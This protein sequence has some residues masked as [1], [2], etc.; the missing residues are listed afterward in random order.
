MDKDSAANQQQPSNVSADNLA[1]NLQPAR[2]RSSHDQRQRDTEDI[3]SSD[4]IDFEQATESMQVELGDALEDQRMVSSSSAHASAVVGTTAV[5]LASMYLHQET[6]LTE[7]GAT[8]RLLAQQDNN[9]QARDISS[10][11]AW[12]NN[13]FRASLGAADDKDADDDNDDGEPANVSVAN[14]KSQLSFTFDEDDF[15]LQHQDPLDR[16][17]AMTKEN[18]T[19]WATDTAQAEMPWL[20]RR[21]SVIREE[22]S[23]HQL[24]PFATQTP[25]STSTPLAP[26]H[27]NPPLSTLGAPPRPPSFSHQLPSSST[28]KQ[29]PATDSAYS[30]P[31]SHLTEQKRPSSPSK[32]PIIRPEMR[33][34]G[35]NEVH[36]KPSIRVIGDF[37]LPPLKQLSPPHHAAFP[38][39]AEPVQEQQQKQQVMATADLLP[40]PELPGNLTAVRAQIHEQLAEQTMSTSKLDLAFRN[41]EST[42]ARPP[43]HGA[44][45]NAV[46]SQMTLLELEVA[47]TLDISNHQLESLD[48]LHELAPDL[49]ECNT[50]HNRLRFL[51]GLPHGLTKLNAMSNWL[52]NLTS[53]SHL[54]NLQYLNISDNAIDDLMGLSGC[55][56]LRELVAD[57]NGI[58]SLS[59]LP[60]I[61]GLLKL[62]LRHNVIMHFDLTPLKLTRLE[63]LDL[64]HNKIV[65]IDSLAAAP[66][67]VSL[68]LDHNDIAAFELAEPA[69][70]IRCLSLNHNSLQDFDLDRVPALTE[71]YLDGN[72][73]KT[74]RMSSDF[75]VETLHLRR[76]H[77][78][79]VDRATHAERKEASL[80]AHNLHLERL[81]RAKS[82]AL[83]GNLL[84]SLSF[85]TDFVQL[86]SLELVRCGI[87]QLPDDLARQAPFLQRLDVSFN[88]LSDLHGVSALTRLRHLGAMGNDIVDFFDVENAI[89][90]MQLTFLDLRQNP[91]TALFYS[92]YVPP[93]TNAEEQPADGNDDVW[94]EQDQRYM[95]QMNDKLFVKR[96]CYRTSVLF[97][98]RGSLNVLDGVPIQLSE[99]DKVGKAY[100]RIQEKLAKL[101]ASPRARSVSREDRRRASPATGSSH[102]TP[103]S[104]RGSPLYHY[105][106]H[107][108]DHPGT[109]PS[110]FRTPAT[111][112]SRDLYQDLTSQ[113]AVM[114]EMMHVL[115]SPSPS[116]ASAHDTPTPAPTSALILQ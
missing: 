12:S 15:K 5:G 76:Q 38:T 55:I 11:H 69:G 78:M 29:R 82:L 87:R 96:V 21:L 22:P 64:S 97:K 43:K 99:R 41:L 116:N 44:L 49:R 100:A 75:K 25:P 51:S 91:L 10:F 102:K 36:D 35:D 7:Q 20:A 111:I 34:A 98:L 113:S 114:H 67:L 79:S 40:E 53:F 93:S 50:H 33:Q 37:E 16:V 1:Q 94:L 47:E 4:S 19:S 88:N 2:F 30:S 3:N 115:T 58:A 83:S 77:C 60:S 107:L 8:S 66:A 92:N 95:K 42:E 39:A 17:L 62:S 13:R 85:L 108:A 56:H 103:S 86:E 105:R 104:R 63:A 14:S 9:D 32:R 90:G 45:F 68:R 27:R 23:S 73:I 71:L 101:F 57:N 70:K 31:F 18:G 89:L 48:G 72:D 74:L 61:R 26:V 6:M 84:S 52:S 46:T 65:H 59:A 81:Q 109:T 110:H 106:P 28:G 112:V 80:H 24:L 54:T